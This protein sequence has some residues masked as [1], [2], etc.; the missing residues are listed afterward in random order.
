ME[1][2]TGAMQPD[3]IGQVGCPNGG[4]ALAI[5]LVAGGTEALEFGLA[6]LHHGRVLSIPA[7][8]EY[9]SG[10]GL[11]PVVTQGRPHGG[12]DVVAAIGDAGLDRIG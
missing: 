12:H 6:D 3:I 8:A 4:T 7:Q 11:D 5:G 9:I 1:V 10:H 2:L